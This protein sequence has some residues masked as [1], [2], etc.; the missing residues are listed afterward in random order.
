MIE[1]PRLGPWEESLVPGIDTEVPL[2]QDPSPF[3]SRIRLGS[4]SFWIPSPTPPSFVQAAVHFSS[5]PLG[6]R[7]VRLRRLHN[8]SSHLGI[9]PDPA[10][11]SCRTNLLPSHSSKA[12]PG[13]LGIMRLPRELRYRLYIPPLWVPSSP[14]RLGLPARS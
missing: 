9:R 3:F 4:M 13:P 6:D 12:E 2:G 11:G 5:H 14:Y 7:T 10:P 8:I 1:C